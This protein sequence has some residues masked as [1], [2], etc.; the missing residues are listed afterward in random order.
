MGRVIA[1]YLP[2][3]GAFA[4]LVVRGR[5]EGLI[6]RCDTLADLRDTLVGLEKLASGP[7]GRQDAATADDLK[8]FAEAEPGR[9]QKA[10]STIAVE[11]RLAAAPALT[12]QVTDRTPQILPG[13]GGSVALTVRNDGSAPLIIR[14]VA[15]QHA[16]L[17]VRP[18]ELPLTIAAGKAERVEF[19]ISAARLTPGEYRSEVYLSANAGGQSAEDLR[20]GWFK[21]TSEIRVVVGGPG[22][23]GSK[24]LPYP[25]DSPALPAISGCAT[26]LLAIVITVPAVLILAGKAA[27]AAFAVALPVK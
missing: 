15:T 3:V 6:A 20:G 27:H 9:G 7:S 25:S 22:G 13:G 26:V 8:P 17:N 2:T 18:V 24:S 21:H 16:W 10:I 19:F 11:P 23:S 12:T 5:I 14:M 1:T 4:S